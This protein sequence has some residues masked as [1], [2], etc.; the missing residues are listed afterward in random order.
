V[1]P[2]G[3]YGGAPPFRTEPYPALGFTCFPIVSPA[4]KEGISP[5]CGVG[6]VLHPKPNE[7]NL[8]DGQPKPSRAVRTLSPESTKPTTIKVE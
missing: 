7:P 1:V 2:V 3:T 4:T 5:L 6:P 8:V